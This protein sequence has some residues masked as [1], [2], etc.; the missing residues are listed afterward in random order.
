MIKGQFQ[1]VNLENRRW[2]NNRKFFFFHCAEGVEFTGA[3]RR[4]AELNSWCER[5]R[6]KAASFLL[7]PQ[8]N[9]AILV[10]RGDAVIFRVTGDARE[11]VLSS[12]LVVFFE[13]KPLKKIQP[14]KESHMV[15]LT[16]L[17]ALWETWVCENH[18]FYDSW[19]LS[20][21]KT[22]LLISTLVFFLMVG[23]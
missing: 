21:M 9:L 14:Y 8:A 4:A 12:F 15:L 18:V 3:A 1:H 7:S 6:F 2:Q 23:K 5:T 20:H 11:R 22:S 16:V 10:S 19:P 13:G 17:V